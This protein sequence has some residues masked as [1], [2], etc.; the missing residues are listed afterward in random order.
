MV[1]S[2]STHQQNSAA[3]AKTWI[4]ETYGLKESS[5]SIPRIPADDLSNLKDGKIPN[6]RCRLWF[7]RVTPITGKNDGYNPASKYGQNYIY[8]KDFSPGCHRQQIKVK[9]ENYRLCLICSTLR[10][11]DSRSGPW[12]GCGYGHPGI[13]CLCWTGNFEW[14]WWG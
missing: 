10:A 13:C 2:F 5:V 1:Q 4:A 7:I 9:M 8:I 3:K 12:I 11:T 14:L 6:I